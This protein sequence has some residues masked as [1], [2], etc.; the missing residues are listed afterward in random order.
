M[1]KQLLP[2]N[3]QKV[4]EIHHYS[5]ATPIQEQMWSAI[6]SGQSVLGVSPTGTGK[7]L[8]YVLPLLTKIDEQGGTQYL[9][10]VPSQE[11]AMQVTE[12]IRE[13]SVETSITVTSVIG[14]ANIKRQIERLKQKPHIIVGTPGRVWELIQQ[15]KIKAHLLKTVVL[16]EVDQLMG[17]SELN[18]AKNC[19]QRVQKECQVIAVSATGHN[20]V[21]PVEKLVRRELKVIDV[22]EVDNSQGDIEHVY[23]KTPARRKKEALK[24]LAHFENRHILVFFTKVEELGIVA[25]KLTYDG[26]ANVT[27]ASDQSKFEREGALRLF[28]EKKV[29]LLLTTDVAARGLDLPDVTDVVHYDLPYTSESYIHRSGRTGRMGKDGR[30]ITLLTEQDERDYRRLLKETTTEATERF[31]HGG[32]L[33]TQ[34]PKGPVAPKKVKTKKSKQKRR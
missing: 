14:Q 2:P 13:W 26:V 3:L 17:H 8:S 19:L 25:D 32:A 28:R 34:L 1:L 33:H 12:V 23:I 15:K 30:V 11:L 24:H 22:T 16:D 31:I 5:E 10:L 9:V 29:S 6:H 27:L 21:E 18:A 7:T 4:W 20:V